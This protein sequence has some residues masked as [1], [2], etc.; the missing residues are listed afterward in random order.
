MV[1]FAVP[2]DDLGTFAQLVLNAFM[3]S[4]SYTIKNRLR[5]NFRST[6]ALL[7][8]LQ[9]SVAVSHKIQFGTPNAP[10][11]PNSSKVNIFA[12]T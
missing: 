10:A 11:F 2:K 4:K 5:P 12:N 9:S 6:F 3:I 7:W 1:H 8:G